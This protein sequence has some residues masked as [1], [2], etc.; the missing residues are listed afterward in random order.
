[1][2]KKLEQLGQRLLEASE[3]LQKSERHMAIVPL[4][5]SLAAVI[6]VVGGL[7]TALQDLESRMAQP[8]SV[9][10]QADLLADDWVLL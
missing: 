4:Q 8:A 7:G 3:S 2:S 9:P 5:E 6:E 1:M 10:V